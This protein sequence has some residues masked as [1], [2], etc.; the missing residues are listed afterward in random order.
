MS[1]DP[2]NQFLQAVTK[3]FNLEKPATG[4][5]VCL[6]VQQFL[7]E[8]FPTESIDWRATQF[9]DGS[10]KIEAQSSTAQS[11]LYQKIA[12]LLIDLE[13]LELPEPV[14]EIKVTKPSN[15]YKM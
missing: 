8:K 15:K 10:L 13:T 5:L 9:Y 14:I 7:E 6:R 1:F 12:K 2:A 3:R 4:S 11:S